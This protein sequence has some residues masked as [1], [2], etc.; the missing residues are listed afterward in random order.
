MKA[1]AKEYTILS[2][3]PRPRAGADD[4]AW[5][6]PT[7]RRAGMRYLELYTVLS[8]ALTLLATVLLALAL[9]FVVNRYARE[10]THR[11]RRR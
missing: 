2:R 1:Q 10:R 3:S 5:S 7:A 4:A 11:R 9:G 8:K 6:P